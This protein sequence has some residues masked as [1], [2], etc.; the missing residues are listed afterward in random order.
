MKKTK[1]AYLTVFLLLFSMYC[2]GQMQAWEKAR[3]TQKVV[4]DIVP[5][6]GS[7][8]ASVINTV[9][10]HI[11]FRATTSTYGYEPWITDGTADS[12]KILK[13]I[14][15]GTSGSLTNT[16]V[17]SFLFDSVLLLVINDGVNGNE[18]WRTD[19][20]TNGTYL[21]KDINTGS[22]S[23]DPSNFLRW[24]NKVLFTATTATY[25]NELWETDGT[26]SGT[27]LLK[28]IRTGT[29]SSSASNFYA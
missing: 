17:V 24:G 10:N 27:Q 28:D 2:F 16:T 12:T 18:L 13:D 22:A 15:A 29:A 4:K 14:V 20:T 6:T 3:A 5:G 11:I 23:S 8:N 19:G 1:T 26:L 7:S 9:N 21:L 25:G